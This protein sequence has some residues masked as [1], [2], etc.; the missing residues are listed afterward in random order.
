MAEFLHIRVDAFPCLVIGDAFHAPNENGYWLL[1]AEGAG[2]ALDRHQ[3]R[4]V[5]RMIATC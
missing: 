4:V 1:A 2:Q 3:Q 5:R